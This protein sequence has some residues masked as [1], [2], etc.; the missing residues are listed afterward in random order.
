MSSSTISQSH[1]KTEQLAD[2]FRLFNEL[3]QDLTVSYQNLER[4][5]AKLSD[6]LAAARS[7]RL[8]TL[9]EN[10][11][12][13]ARL[14]QIL[15]ALPAGILIID[16]SGKVADYNP[17]ALEYLDEPLLQRPWSEVAGRSLKAVSENP[18]ERQLPNGKRVGLSYNALTEGAGQLV[19]LSDV[20]EMRALQDLV[21]R[22]NNLS[23]M[24]EM[25]ASL[26]H[27]VRTPL[28]TVI[29]YASQ[30]SRPGL[31]E[32][33]RQQFSSK[34]LERLH[35]LERQVNDML[36][37]AKEG[38]LS[39]ATFALHDLLGN[40]EDAMADRVAGCNSVEFSINNEAGFEIL[41]GNEPAL[42]GAIMNLLNNALDACAGQGVVTL[43]VVRS[44]RQK[45]IF[46]VHDTGPGI[47]KALYKRVFEPFYT[48]KSSGTGLGLAVVDSVVRAHHGKV[49]C[50]SVP[51]LG[52][53]FELE[54]PIAWETKPALP[55][56]FSGRQAKFEELYDEAI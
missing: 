48:T 52:T 47:E 27:Q 56:G 20:S 33:K 6:E 43:T 50:D 18:H 11:K 13:A 9:L 14:R 51:G 23:A 39:M 38:R 36:I 22:Q 42:R 30:M 15:A 53:V 3:S 25:I 31:G 37:F 45:L 2:A 28:S 10:E 24:G 49:S 1:N 12:I 40:V 16:P 44:S 5:V 41:T 4:Q 17:T 19:L 29:L 8:K 7:E 54:M 26:A 21:D 46:T 35:Y 34:I 55:G 32:N